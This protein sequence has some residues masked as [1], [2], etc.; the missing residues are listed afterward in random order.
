MLVQE[1]KDKNDE[2]E[3]A[4]SLLSQRDNKVFKLKVK[5]DECRASN[6]ALQATI[7]KY[8]ATIA[9]LQ[10]TIET[11]KQRNQLLVDKKAK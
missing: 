5:L 4:L 7:V 9:E 3:Q 8:Q 10:A 11:L 2:K 1:V 6:A